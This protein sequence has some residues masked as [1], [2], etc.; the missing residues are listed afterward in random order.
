M[1]AFE[2]KM[3][4]DGMNDAAIA[5]FR[6][7]YEQ[8]VAGEDGIVPEDT[9]EPVEVRIVRYLLQQLSCRMLVSNACC[10][11]VINISDHELGRT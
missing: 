8:L 4:G 3:K 6:H 1:D 2:V 5:S 7:N 11:W 10:V 9:I